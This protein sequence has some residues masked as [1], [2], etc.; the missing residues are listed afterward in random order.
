MHSIQIESLIYEN[1]MQCTQ[2]F[3]YSMNWYTFLIEWLQS[4]PNSSKQNQASQGMTKTKTKDVAK[5]VGMRKR[6]Q[7]N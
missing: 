2:K 6:E 1:S 4:D 5:R 7:E 3:D